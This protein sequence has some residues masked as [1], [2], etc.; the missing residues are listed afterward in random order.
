MDFQQRF[1]G[2]MTVLKKEGIE[3]IISQGGGIPV[4]CIGNSPL[5]GNPNISFQSAVHKFEDEV[6]N[7]SQASTEIQPSSPLKGSPQLEPISSNRANSAALEV[8]PPLSSI[9]H[10][11]SVLTTVRHRKKA[12]SLPQ[13]Y[14]KVNVV[15]NKDLMSQLNSDRKNLIQSPQSTREEFPSDKISQS[16]ICYTGD[17]E[18][19]HPKQAR[20]E[21][22]VQ[23]Y[24][25]LQTTKIYKNPLVIK[26]FTGRPYIRE[27]REKEQLEDLSLEVK[28]VSSLDQKER[29]SGIRFPSSQPRSRV[30][31]SLSRPSQQPESPG[32]YG[33][34]S[35]PTS[36]VYE[37]ILKDKLQRVR[38]IQYNS[39]K[40]TP[41]LMHAGRSLTP[42]KVVERLYPNIAFR[43]FSEKE[44]RPVRD[45]NLLR[46]NNARLLILPT[47]RERSQDKRL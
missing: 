7:L 29:M 32:G 28:K 41:R 5:R 8:L 40:V 15:E 34:D 14:K 43:P 30:G 33:D 16:L 38:D 25:G 24:Q 26:D 22:W 12:I 2:R 1:K 13:P 20:N 44:D 17:F 4:K 21:E 9:D 11:N 3:G 6:V 36:I 31:T 46:G 35:D 23:G 47:L 39:E 45:S 27:P 42:S 19:P 18:P 10:F 37:K